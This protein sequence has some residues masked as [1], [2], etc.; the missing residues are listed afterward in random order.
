MKR[1]L[2]T[3][4]VSA[5]LVFSAQAAD[6]VPVFIGGAEDM[7][8]CGSAAEVVNLKPGGDGFL[9]VR[10]GPGSH[11]EQTDKLRLNKH[12][13]ICDMSP[14]G[15]WYG[16]VYPRDD[17]FNDNQCGVSSSSHKES[18]PYKDNQY[19]RSGWAHVNWLKIFAG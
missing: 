12:V 6:T 7:D 9:A 13:Y 3:A 2:C 16:I 1:I 11:Y 15:M 18:V 19:C 4:I 8:D 5:I 17:N 14:D 10:A